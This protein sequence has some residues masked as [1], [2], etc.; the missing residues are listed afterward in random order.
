MKRITPIILLLICILCFAS[1]KVQKPTVTISG[2]DAAVVTDENGQWLSDADGNPIIEKTDEEG[3]KVTE[4]LSE[5]YIFIDDDNVKSPAYEAKVHPDFSIVNSGVEP[6]YENREGTIQHS[7]TLAPKEE[8]DYDAYINNVYATYSRLQI[9]MG[10][11]EE[12][13]ISN[14]N[15]KRFSMAYIDDDGS[16]IQAYCYFIK[17]GE[18]IVCLTLTSKDGGLNSASD[19]DKYIEEMEYTFNQ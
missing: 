6:L 15:M 9:E 13:T 7:A 18:R 14:Q 1:C 3:N 5:D 16:S 17:S 4:V 11:I 12:I 10:E 19:A 2:G 8:T